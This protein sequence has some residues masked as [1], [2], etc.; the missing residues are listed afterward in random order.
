MKEVPIVDQY[1]NCGLKSSVRQV[2]KNGPNFGRTYQACPKPRFEDRCQFFQFCGAF[3]EEQNQTLEKL[4]SEDRNK[5]FGLKPEEA[6]ENATIGDGNKKNWV[7]C[8]SSGG[9]IYY[10]NRLTKVSQWIK[11]LFEK[12]K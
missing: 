7:K 9:Q 4:A 1:C 6:V 8:K 11:P 2:Q 3:L 12:S 5:K 10:H